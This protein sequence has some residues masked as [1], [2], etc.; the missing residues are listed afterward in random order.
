[1]GSFTSVRLVNA[2]QSASW[3]AWMRAD[4]GTDSAGAGGAGGRGG[5]GSK[6]Q[7]RAGML[8]PGVSPGEVLLLSSSA[9]AWQ[10]SDVVTATR[11]NSTFRKRCVSP[12]FSE[13]DLSAHASRHHNS[14]TPTF[15][16]EAVVHALYACETVEVF[17]FYIPQSELE[18]PTPRSRA[19]SAQAPPAPFRYHYFEARSVDAAAEQPSKPWTYRSHD[20]PIESARLRHMSTKACLFRQ[21]L[22]PG[23]G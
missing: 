21:H 13:A 19:S 18:E 16:F 6:L 2:P 7:P 15:G 17:G 11:L 14:L 3:A 20:Y 1:M 10:R 23:A 12:F 9:A 8:P 5:N 22:P 4:G